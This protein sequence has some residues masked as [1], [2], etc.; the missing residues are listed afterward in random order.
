MFTGCAF[1]DDLVSC[2]RS[3]DYFDR[4]TGRNIQFN[5]SSPLFSLHMRTHAQINLF[6]NL[7]DEK[8]DDAAT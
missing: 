3:Y 4:I 2:A 6:G 1:N 8:K 5:Y 7:L